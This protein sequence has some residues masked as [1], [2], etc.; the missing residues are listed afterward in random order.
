MNTGFIQKDCFI[1][2]VKINFYDY[3]V[4]NECDIQ[5][6]LVTVID[7]LQTNI[8]VKF[9]DNLKKEVH[10]YA[11]VFNDQDYQFASPIGFY[12]DEFE[13]KV[14]EKNLQPS[15]SCNC[16]LNYLY[17]HLE[18]KKT[19]NITCPMTFGEIANLL[20]NQTMICLTFKE[21]DDSNHY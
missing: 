19:S 7:D 10:R 20:I 17:A 11:P 13:E 2:G 4:E 8:S 6:P 14:L 18:G 5:L 21:N 3:I 1:R 12:E 9:L 16:I 15:I